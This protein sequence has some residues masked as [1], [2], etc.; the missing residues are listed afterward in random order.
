MTTAPQI[1]QS[2]LSWL[3]EIVGPSVAQTVDRESSFFDYG[4]DSLALVR[5]GAHLSELFGKTVS[6]DMIFDHPT[7]RALA[8]FLADQPSFDRI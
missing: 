6:V 3:S 2:I 5:L 7:P 1:E 8:E 4:A